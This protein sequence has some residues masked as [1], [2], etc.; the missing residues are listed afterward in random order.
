MK[1]VPDELEK[2]LDKFVEEQCGGWEPKEDD[3]HIKYIENV[4]SGKIVLA[5]NEKNF[6]KNMQKVRRMREGKW[7]NK[8]TND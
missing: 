8:K 4:V 3:R 5:E 7:S 6:F 1:K 2:K